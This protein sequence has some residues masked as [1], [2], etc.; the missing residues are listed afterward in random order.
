M[1]PSTVSEELDS[2]GPVAWVLVIPTTTALMN[3]FLDGKITEKELFDLT[4]LDAS[5][6]ALYLCSALV[7]EEYRRIGITKRL[8][9]SAIQNIRAVH[10]LNALFVWPFTEDGNAAA[11]AIARLVGL[12][13]F[14][15]KK[16]F[17]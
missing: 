13:L 3:R 5:Y 14:R 9:L 16:P 4:P 10:P 8:V 6:E 2:N 1:H 15:R 17:P 7:L 11:E 12:P